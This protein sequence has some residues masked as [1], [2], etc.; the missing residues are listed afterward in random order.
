VIGKAVVYFDEALKLPCQSHT[1]RDFCIY[2]TGQT[3]TGLAEAKA[4]TKLG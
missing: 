2:L 1:E 3:T 4:K